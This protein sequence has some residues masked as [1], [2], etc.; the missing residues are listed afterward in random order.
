MENFVVILE[1]IHKGCEDEF[2]MERKHS[3]MFSRFLA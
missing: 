3:R 1:E 2:H